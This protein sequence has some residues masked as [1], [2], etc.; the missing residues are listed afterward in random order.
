MNEVGKLHCV[1]YE[2]NGHIVA[3]QIEIALSGIEFGCETM[4]IAWQVT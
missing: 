3:D 4:H 1:L 2:E